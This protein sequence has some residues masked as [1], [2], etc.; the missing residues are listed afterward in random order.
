MSGKVNNIRIV[1][2][3]HIYKYI[4][5]FIYMCKHTASRKHAHTSKF[6][7]ILL[8]TVDLLGLNS[9]KIKKALSKGH[10]D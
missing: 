9:T 3:T 7:V 6:I 10:L 5:I 4:Y 8:S 1:L 2:S